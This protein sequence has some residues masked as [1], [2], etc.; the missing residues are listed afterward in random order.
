M[1]RSMNPSINKQ[2][3]DYLIRWTIASPPSSSSYQKRGDREL[4]YIR[5]MIMIRDIHTYIHGV[6]GSA[7][8]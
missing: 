3:D 2:T 5:M 7:L 8:R 1:S 4:T 6:V